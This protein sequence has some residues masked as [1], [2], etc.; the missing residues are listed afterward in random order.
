MNKCFACLENRA[1]TREHIIPQSIGGRL[2]DLLYCKNCNEK[3]GKLLDTEIFKSFG[4]IATILG[5]QRDRGHNQP[6]EVKET[7]SN[8]ELYFNGHRFRRKKP[9]VKVKKD[10]EQIEI[11]VTARSKKELEKVM[12]SLKDKYQLPG[13]W[14]C[15]E[16]EHP[17]P[18]DIKYEQELDNKLI[19]RAITKI[20]YSFLCHKLPQK[21]VLSKDFNNTRIYI[22]DG[23][24]DDL[25]CANFKYTGFMCDYTRPLHKIHIN[26]NRKHGL[27]V[28]YVMLFGIFRFTI[29]LSRTFHSS[30]EW[31]S[32]D[33]TYDPVLRREIPGNPNFVAHEISEDQILRPKQTKEIIL[34]ELRKTYK[35]IDNY[36]KDSKL[37][38]IEVE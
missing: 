38:D 14:K 28:G 9:I 17:G 3:F 33:Y 27:V 25:A 35:I 32:V 15:F 21:D 10:Q 36:V 11:D 8:I 7:I 30:I 1:L 22:L 12:K 29:L 24:V 5:I 18:L 31:P 16:E 23:G 4:H 2:T 34:K 26:L 37:L 20:A 13:N 19:R 6:F